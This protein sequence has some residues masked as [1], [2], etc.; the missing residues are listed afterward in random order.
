MAEH[1]HLG[2]QVLAE[3]TDLVPAHSGMESQEGG[4]DQLMQSAVAWGSA[5]RDEIGVKSIWVASNAR[6]SSLLRRGVG[7]DKARG[8]LNAVVWEHG[9]K[10]AER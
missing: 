4:R 7:K 2:S 1:I 6:E 8:P 10:G 3:N 5:G 9:D